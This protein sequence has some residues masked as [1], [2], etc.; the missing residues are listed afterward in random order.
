[1]WHKNYPFHLMYVCTLPCKVTRAKIVIK[2]CNFTLLLA[3]TRGLRPKKNNFLS[4]LSTSF[5]YIVTMKVRSIH[6]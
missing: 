4:A 6:H 1:M 3:K 5:V 2:Q